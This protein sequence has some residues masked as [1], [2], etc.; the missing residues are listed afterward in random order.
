V[1]DIREAPAIL[2]IEELVKNGANVTWFDPLVNVDLPGK[3]IGLLPT[4]DLG[5]VVTP[6]KSIDFSTW[7]ESKTKVFDLSS[8]SKNYGWP[9]FL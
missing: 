8:N 6:H 7:I 9:K 5:L 3:Q 2:L 4:I 1:S